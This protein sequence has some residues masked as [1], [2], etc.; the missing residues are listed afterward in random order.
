MPVQDKACK[1]ST[2]FLN[3]FLAWNSGTES[4]YT[5]CRIFQVMTIIKIFGYW[6]FVV[7]D[8]NLHQRQSYLHT[9]PF[10]DE[11]TKTIDLVSHNSLRSL[12][13]DGPSFKE[14]KQE[15]RRKNLQ[16]AFDYSYGYDIW[17]RLFTAASHGNVLDPRQPPRPKCSKGK[18]HAPSPKPLPRIHSRT[19][20][21]KSSTTTSVPHPNVS[22]S[23]GSKR[24]GQEHSSQQ[25]PRIH[26]TAPPGKRPK[27]VNFQQHKENRKETTPHSNKKVRSTF[28]YYGP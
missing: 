1:D 26:P 20:P 27:H 14:F 7:K 2:Q 25:S 3:N 19:L 18:G 21:G 5:S 10:P 12:T 22:D 9:S 4:A 11:I 17:C 8:M 23:K 6:S 16:C 28:C 15:N 13:K 24:K